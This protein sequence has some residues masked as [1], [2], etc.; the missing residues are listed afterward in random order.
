MN[1]YERHIGDYLKDTAHLSLLEHGVYG[2]LL[3]V[4]YT[5]ENGIEDGMT[6]RLIGA[7]SKDEL[8]ALAV[9]LA[10][11]FV[12][13]A[14]IW[15][16]SRCDREIERYRK[17]AEH[18][19][20]VGKLGGRPRKAETQSE[21][22]QNPAG[23]QTEPESNPQETLASNQKPVTTLS[24]KEKARKRATSFAAEEIELPPWLSREV[25]GEWVKERRSR[26]KAITERGAAAQIKTLDEF[27][28]NGHAPE[29]VIAH[30]IASGNQGLY[31]PPVLKGVV[32]QFEPRP[33][34]VWKPPP[35]MTPEEK[36]ASDKAREL[37]LSAFKIITK[38]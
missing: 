21:P 36:A 34:E 24:S 30:A 14:G 8:A 3:D 38:A 10:E 7:R 32:Q 35:P 4:Y 12:L 19:R 2:R 27:R 15:T 22:E 6:A 5:R 9:V 23:F 25:W 1:Y 29:R 11:F 31:P 33:V 26:G 17:R 13:Q 37:A 20:T 28:K 16:H 18:N